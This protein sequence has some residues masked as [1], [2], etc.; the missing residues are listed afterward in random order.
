MNIHVIG[1]RLAQLRNE[2]GAGPGEAGWSQARVAEVTGLTVN[3][4]AR[5][6]Q[7]GGASIE[8]FV[9]MLTFYHQRGYS[10]GWILL[11][12]NSN[13]SKVTLG[14]TVKA[15]DSNLVAV[16][17]EGIKQSLVKEID[18]LSAVLTA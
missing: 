10:I 12:D 2:L 8:A 18:T 1:K 5:M 9:T 14:E 16:R 11:A 15:V 4:V 3:Q 13:V 6:E 17:L 7:T